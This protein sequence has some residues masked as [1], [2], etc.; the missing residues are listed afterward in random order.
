VN[1]QPKG[2]PHP[3]SRVIARKSL[4]FESKFAR[5]DQ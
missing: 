1:A 3:V 4:S 2:S 5:E